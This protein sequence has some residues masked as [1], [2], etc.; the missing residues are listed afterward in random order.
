MTREHFEALRERALW[1]RLSSELKWTEELLTKYADQIC[2]ET[3]SSNENVLWTESLIR[4]FA[5]KLNWGYLSRNDAL[6]LKSPEVVRPFALYWHWSDKTRLT[7][8]TPDFIEEMKDY[9]DWET[10]LQNASYEQQELL[11]QKYFQY[12]SL[13]EMEDSSY[14]SR[15]IFDEYV[16]NN[17][18]IRANEILN[19]TNSESL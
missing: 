3:I 15:T 14:L 5:N 11:L 4:R 2:W 8:W 7:A 18:Q 9:L 13:L 17:W 1:D 6:S 19:Q 12:I 10:L 16:D